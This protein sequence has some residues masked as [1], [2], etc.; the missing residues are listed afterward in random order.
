M[1]SVRLSVC[2]SSTQEMTDTPECRP[3]DEENHSALGGSLRLLVKAREAAGVGVGGGVLCAAEQRTKPYC[4]RALSVRRAY[5]PGVC[6]QGALTTQGSPGPFKAGKGEA[7][8]YGRRRK[9]EERLLWVRQKVLECLRAVGTRQGVQ[10]RTLDRGLLGERGSA[11]CS[12]C[13]G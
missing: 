9:R 11:Y 5:V 2:P 6:Q 1:P 12:L 8:G 3:W 7:G 4:A 13:A 10:H